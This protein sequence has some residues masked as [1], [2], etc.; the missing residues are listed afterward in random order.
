MILLDYFWVFGWIYGERDEISK[1]GKFRGPTL[2]GR[3]P[4]LRHRDPTQQRK[5]TP[6][7]GMSTSR[8]SREGGLDK[9]R[10]RRGV[11]KLRRVEGVRCTTTP[12]RSTV[13]RHVFLSCFSISLF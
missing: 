7:H 3:G 9:P 1:F 11:A 8:S 4:T 6:R 5:S 10:V 2:R 13:H 12:W